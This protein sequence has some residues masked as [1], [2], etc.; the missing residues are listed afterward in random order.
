MLLFGMKNV[1]IGNM[2]ILSFLTRVMAFQF[3]ASKSQYL[4]D[5][6]EQLFHV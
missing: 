6:Q 3:S 1:I 5:F 4:T 2:N